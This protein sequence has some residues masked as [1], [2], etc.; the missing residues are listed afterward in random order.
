MPPSPPG[1][2][3]DGGV[4]SFVAWSC[5]WCVI[6]FERST[7]QPAKVTTIAAAKRW[8]FMVV[9]PSGVDLFARA[10][11]SA[12]ERRGARQEEQREASVRD[13]GVGAIVPA[14]VAVLR[15]QEVGG[16]FGVPVA[17]CEPVGPEQRS[18]AFQSVQVI[19]E[20]PL[21]VCA[22]RV[23][24]G[25]EVS[26]QPGE[27]TIERRVR[28]GL[29][30]EQIAAEEQTADPALGHARIARLLAVRPVS[31]ATVLA[32]GGSPPGLGLLEVRARNVDSGP[33]AGR[34][35]EQG[36]GGIRVVAQC[37]RL[38]V[39]DRGAVAPLSVREL[40]VEQEAR[41]GFQAFSA[42]RWIEASQGQRSKC[43]LIG[44][45][46]RRVAD[47]SAKLLHGPGPVVETTR[48]AGK[49]HLVLGYDT[50][51]RCEASIAV[52]VQQ[53]PTAALDRCVD[54]RLRDL[55]GLARR[56]AGR[57]SLRRRLPGQS[58]ELG[59]TGGEEARGAGEA[60][61]LG[62]LMSIR[63]E[64]AHVG[65]GLNS[66]ALSEVGVLVEVDPYA[67]EVLRDLAQLRVGIRHGIHL[68][69]DPSPVGVE[70]EQHGPLLLVSRLHPV[71]VS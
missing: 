22:A 38:R 68:A 9:A 39:P 58:I 60:D 18:K 7:P 32:L 29:A 21:L 53:E 56:L 3:I 2:L 12:Q 8:G 25:G 30:R 42:R 54:C 65:K 26:R 31:P 55:D 35:P 44:A 66:I 4:D 27:S 49:E 37:G 11:A 70:L 45:R 67:D 71:V 10:S 43:G 62:H 34:E 40:G 64:D 17:A 6:A 23:L 51:G 47:G 41:A 50:R 33:A 19:Q 14:P 61:Q 36:V 59:S 28:A 16:S 1:S 52:T 5:C 69:A 46:E 15:A 24:S 20:T 13:R 48:E 63:V 57:A